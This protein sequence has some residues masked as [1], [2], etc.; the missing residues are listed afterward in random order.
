MQT[1]AERRLTVEESR[2]LFSTL[3]AEKHSPGMTE[4]LSLYLS[5]S[6]T[7]TR[8]C[9][10]E[11]T[12]SRGLRVLTWS[13]RRVHSQ[14]MPQMM[15]TCELNSILVQVSQSSMFNTSVITLHKIWSDNE[16][17]H[18]WISDDP[19]FPFAR[20][21]V[22]GRPHGGQDYVAAYT[23]TESKILG[24]VH[25]TELCPPDSYECYSVNLSSVFDV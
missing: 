2:S 1:V 5:T 13:L 8:G 16:M 17:Y 25:T 11:V 19:I 10:V 22:W 15:G 23:Y 14:E 4:Q 18:L 9:H 24:C 12:Q 21:P 3:R 6:V 20:A 7:F